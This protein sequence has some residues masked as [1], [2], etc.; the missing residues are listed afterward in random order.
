MAARGEL[1]I[2]ESGGRFLA[3]SR[4]RFHGKFLPAPLSAERSNGRVEGEEK[5][6]IRRWKTKS[7]TH[8]VAET[9]M[10]GGRIFFSPLTASLFF[11]STEPS[12][13]EAPRNHRNVVRRGEVSRDSLVAVISSRIEDLDAEAVSSL[14]RRRRGV[15]IRGSSRGILLSKYVATSPLMPMYLGLAPPFPNSLNVGGRGAKWN[16]LLEGE[17][18]A[19][20]GWRGGG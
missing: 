2:A 1:Y 4:A 13:P 19:P 8:W 17:T 16:G 12:R 5:T 15:R 9:S 20:R 6:G 7:H 10:R 3:A 14:G 18:T 11:R